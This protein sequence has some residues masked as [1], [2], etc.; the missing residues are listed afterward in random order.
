M[1]ETCDRCYEEYDTED[2]I[3]VTADD[4]EPKKEDGLTSRILKKML[5]VPYDA[6]CENCYCEFIQ[7]H[8]KDF[9]KPNYEKAY[10]ILMDYWDSL[11]DDEKAYIDNRLK[12]VGV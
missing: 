10:D 4:F 9:K 5:K 1:N 3:W 7:V 8:K 6:L 11:P 12:E 2:L